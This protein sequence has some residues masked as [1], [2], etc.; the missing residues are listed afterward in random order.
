MNDSIWN[1]DDLNGDRKAVSKGQA[2]EASI[3]II[4][5]IGSWKRGHVCYNLGEKIS[6]EKECLEHRSDT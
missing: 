1:S 6:T 4:Y 2:Y 3:R 5:F